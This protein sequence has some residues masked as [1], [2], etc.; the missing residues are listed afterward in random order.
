VKV[1]NRIKKMRKRDGRMLDFDQDRITIAIWKAIRATNA[2][3]RDLAEKLSDE[4]VRVLNE[5]VEQYSDRVPNVEDIQDVVE[6]V[7]IE[8]GQTEVAKAYILYRKQHS[9][10]RGLVGQLTS[11]NL[12]DA[13]LKQEDWRVRENANMNFSLQ[14]L[15]VH[16]SGAIIAQYWLEKVYP[17][18]VGR[19][20]VE[21]DYHLHDLSCLAPYCVGWDLA[22]LLR[23]G[24]KGAVGKIESRP[25]KHLRTALMHA[26]NFI[27]TLQGEAA[28][29]QAFSNF[30][31]LLAPFIR[32][33]NL[34]YK[35]VK[36]TMQ[37]FLYNMMV[38]TR[39][40]FQ[41]PFENITLDLNVPKHMENESVCAGGKFRDE[42][43]GDFQE[44]MNM[45]NKA[46]CEV[47][48]E[49]DASGR[50]FTF[51]IPT[52][53]ITKEFDWGNE[54]T[55]DIFEM[56]AKYGIPYFANFVNSDMKPED[57]RSMC[58]RLRL[59][60]REL[61]KRGGGLF[62]SNPLTGSVGVVT[63]NMPRIGYFARDD[64]DFFDR[65]EYLM[66]LARDSLEIKRKVIER[67]TAQGLYPYSAFYLRNI[68][69]AF[70]E[71][72]KNHFNTIGLVGMN[73]ALVNFMG[74]E[75]GI[76]SKQGHAFAIKVLDFMRGHLAEFQNETGN[77][78]NL[79]A[80]PAEGTSYRLARID[81][82][83][84]PDIVVT[85]ND[86]FRKGAA[87]FYTNST[88]LPVN[89]TSDVFEALEL[90]DD[91]QTKYTGGTVLHCFLGER[92]PDWEPAALLVKKVFE[93][94]KLPY[95]S[96][97]PTFSV[98]PKHG[99]LAGEHEYCPKCD[100][101]IGYAPKQAA[102]AAAAVAVAAAAKR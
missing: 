28:G 55:R 32:Y 24:F 53:N 76:A 4:V 31:T 16:V 21:G 6:K 94:F 74:S 83:K 27:Y 1:Y 34:D 62:G 63:I 93:N 75:S 8:S 17:P 41:T 25:A 99:Y 92:L 38:P 30:D 22:D 85:N 78:Y 70:G 89:H 42:A 91:L 56:T 88:Q 69:Q 95:F 72:W 47:M 40:G 10:L 45:F 96:I 44:E 7:L 39:V 71:Y 9:E 61:R 49:G 86:G 97:T 73:E 81:K 77:I 67:F 101:E 68:K 82:K 59:D 98:C 79:E 66:G 36:Q 51:P 48:T 43:Y 29:A 3:T 13:Y 35:Q 65:L 12:V 20:H 19:A 90:Q 50:V 87:P 60:Q 14:G 52:Y 23:V 84:Y 37:E 64:S 11:T 46:F 80:T 54:V 102:Q 57:A 58:C 2:G 15:N 100:A 5:R 33:D 26:V 18:V